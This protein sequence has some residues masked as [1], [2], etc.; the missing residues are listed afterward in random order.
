MSIVTRTTRLSSATRNP[1][2]RRLGRP[3]LGAVSLMVVSAFL[4]PSTAA[5]AAA[6]ARSDFSIVATADQ[7]LV[8]AGSSVVFDF[9]VRRTGG[10]RGAVAWTVKGLPAGATSAIATKRKDSFR[11]S[12][13]TPANAPTAES[14]LVLSGR[15]GSKLRSRLLRLT[16]VARAPG[17]GGSASVT[18]VAPPAASVATTVA[19]VTTAP[20]ATIAPTV[21]TPT[22][23]PTSTAVGPKFELLIGSSPATMF[24]GDTTSYNLSLDRS[25]GYQGP[26]TFSVSGAPPGSA[27][28]FDP[29]ETTGLRTKLSVIAA[30]GAPASTS[31]LT[32]TATA[33]TTTKSLTTKLVIWRHPPNGQV[34]VRDFDADVLPGESF[35]VTV[36]A[37]GT[38][39]DGGRIRVETMHVRGAAQER[40]F[41]DVMF[42]QVGSSLT[43]NVTA[44]PDFRQE[45]L[46]VNSSRNSGIYPVNVRPFTMRASIKSFQVDR[47]KTVPI[48]FD[49]NVAPGIDP[50]QAMTLARA[51]LNA[52]LPVP[53]YEFRLGTG[54]Y[55]IAEVTAKKTAPLGKTTETF[56]LYTTIGTRIE[57]VRIPIEI[58]VID[59]T[60]TIK[61]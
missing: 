21:S 45:T 31:T 43:F 44:G 26:V 40:L 39:V 55:W 37:V 34:A 10:F 50:A 16:V 18:T 24:A 30:A 17:V 61:L 47:G 46:H 3:L 14:T 22:T 15:S 7:Q 32:I 36:D 4:V 53:T 8:D 33:G 23:L 2:G 19:P 13:A 54:G 38:P 12:V 27:T 1:A 57:S 60:G 56:T 9:T 29:P 49:I 6:K 11:L 35:N 20:P 25:S 51:P 59:S 28:L 58:E 48:R 42:M 41:G 5:L 52:N